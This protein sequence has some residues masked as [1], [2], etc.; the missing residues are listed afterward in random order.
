MNPKKYRLLYLV[1]LLISG[2]GKGIGQDATEIVRKSDQKFQGERSSITTMIMTIKR[3][4][5]ERSIEFKTWTSGKAYAL[6]LITSPPKESGQ[7]FMKMKN[8]MWNWNPTINR[9]IKLPPSMMSQGWMGSDFS[10]DDIL[11][12]SSIVV[13]YTHDLAGTEKYNGTD[14]F[15]IILIPREDA[16]VVWGKLIKWISIA[17]FDQLKTEY[18]DEDEVLVKTEIASDIKKMDDRMIPTYFEVIPAE[19]PD[20]KTLVRLITVKFNVLIDEGFFSQQ[21]MKKVR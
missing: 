5:W 6:T 18:Y 10:N 15:K 7:T 4:K 2:M 16:A 14:C 11:K 12:E 21:N 9:L 20:N 8:E 19:K 3:P 1:F 17:G 13:D